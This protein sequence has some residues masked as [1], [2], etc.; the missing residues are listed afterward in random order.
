M[1]HKITLNQER[2]DSIKNNQIF[3]RPSRMYEIK[4]QTFDIL[5][6]KLLNNINL[7]LKTRNDKLSL[8]KSSFLFKK[9]LFLESQLW[10]KSMHVCDV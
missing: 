6:E 4:E 8:L 2:L 7:Y 9:V 10:S 1:K 3:K 5:Y